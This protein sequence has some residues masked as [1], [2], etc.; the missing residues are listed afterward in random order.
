[1]TK[2]LTKLKR[3][4]Q[5]IDHPVIRRQVEE[6][7]LVNHNVQMGEPL[8]RAPRRL[9]LL[10]DEFEEVLTEVGQDKERA[11]R[12]LNNLLNNFRQYL[13]L[14]YG[15]WSLANCQTAHLIKDEL[16]VQTALEVMAGNAYWSQALAQVGVKVHSTDSLEWA[17][18]S[19]TGAQP[20]YPVEDL[21]ADQA[22]KKYHAVDLILCSWSPNFGQGDLETIAAWRKYNPNSH[23]LFIG[24]K[25]GAT[26]SSEFWRR[27]WFKN[28]TA[29]DKINFSL[30]SFDFIDEQV[31][32]I[33]NEF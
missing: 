19:T 32:E 21:T 1:M 7:I 29:L 17:K 4:E 23:L 3:L 25:N 10:P 27:D 30:Q 33:N 18:T 13:S 8:D 31:F 22:V 28:S 9:G 16:H 11:L 26:N 6:I 20:F 24:E 14:T 5:E 15:I 2:F 12:Y